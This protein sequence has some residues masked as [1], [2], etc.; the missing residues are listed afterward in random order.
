MTRGELAEILEYCEAATE[1]PWTMR[2]ARDEWTAHDI[3]AGENPERPK[4]RIAI[5]MGDWELD[6]KDDFAFIARARTD[7][8]KLARELQ[9]AKRLLRLWE[10][11]RANNRSYPLTVTHAFLGGGE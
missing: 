1:G 7:L 10:F 9:E 8:P 4:A 2:E 11:A 5:G 6:V 3:V